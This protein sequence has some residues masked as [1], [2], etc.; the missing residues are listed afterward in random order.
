MR[1]FLH[2][3]PN[4]FSASEETNG[5]ISGQNSGQIYGQNSGGQLDDWTPRRSFLH[6]ES[7]TP[8]LHREL[9]RKFPALLLEC[10]QHIAASKCVCVCVHVFCRQC[11][12][13]T[14]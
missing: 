4:E 10:Q 9:G 13:F 5:Q 11:A 2:A 3:I 8:S 7:G 6:A 1:G 12:C 14:C